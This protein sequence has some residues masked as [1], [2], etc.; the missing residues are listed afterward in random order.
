[1]LV[2][3]SRFRVDRGALASRIGFDGASV[4]LYL[5]IS[6]IRDYEVVDDN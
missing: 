6:C 2:H 3:D 4:M 1:M 5:L